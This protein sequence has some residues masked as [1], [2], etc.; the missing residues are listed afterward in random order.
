MTN[1]DSIPFEEYVER[2]EEH[3]ASQQ[4]RISSLEEE[5]AT[6]RRLSGDL[7]RHLTQANSD[8]DSTQKNLADKVAAFERESNRKLELL[9][10]VDRLQKEKDAR[11][12]QDE[13]ITFGRRFFIA[14]KEYV[15]RRIRAE[16]YEGGTREARIMLD[17][18]FGACY[19]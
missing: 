13:T 8:L 7:R 17:N 16:F 2:A 19:E 14:G 5:L 18:R 9:N 1:L 6:E 15:V 3:S 4:K 12:A 10:E 11:K